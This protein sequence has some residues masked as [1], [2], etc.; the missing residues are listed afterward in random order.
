MDISSSV[1]LVPDT[2]IRQIFTQLYILLRFSLR[3][4]S[5]QIWEIFPCKYQISI[6]AK[7]PSLVLL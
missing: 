1:Q 6:C 5:V 7:S 4:V 2:L 3:H